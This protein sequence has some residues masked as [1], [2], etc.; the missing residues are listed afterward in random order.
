M[1]EAATSTAAAR[2]RGIG[3]QTFVSQIGKI[4][5]RLLPKSDIERWS[6]A[7]QVTSETLTCRGATE[8]PS[9]FPPFS[10]SAMS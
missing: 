6:R 8:P 9:I 10:C 7:T 5:S 1:I 3:Y 2:G 4:G